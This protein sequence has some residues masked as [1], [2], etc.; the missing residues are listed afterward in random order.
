MNL[1]HTCSNTRLVKKGFINMT[2]HWLSRIPPF[3]QRPTALI[4]SL[5]LVTPSYATEYSVTDFEQLTQALT[6][7]NQNA[8]ADTI[9]ILNDINVSAPLPVIKNDLT[10]IGGDHV[11]N[12]EQQHRLLVI[13]NGAVNI[14]DLT[15]TQGKAQGGTGGGGGA[16]LGGALFIVDGQ[17][18]LDRVTFSNNIAQGGQGGNGRG[19]GGL[20]GDG[21]RQGHGGGGGGGLHGDGGGLGNGGGG[22]GGYFGFGGNGGQGLKGNGGGGGGGG[23]FGLG[24]NGGRYGG[25]GGGGYLENGQAGG[26]YGSGGQGASDGGGNGSG[27]GGGGGGGQVGNTGG[28]GIGDRG[29]FGGRSGGGGGGGGNSEKILADRQGGWGADGG[30]GG[31]GGGGGSGGRGLCA[32]NDS[33]NSFAGG[34]GGFGGFGGGGGGGG[35]GE[36]SLGRG[37]HGGDG[38]FGGGGGGGGDGR[39]STDYGCRGGDGGQGGFGGGGGGGGGYF[40]STTND[41]IGDGNSNGAAGGFGGGHGSAGGKAANGRGGGGAGFGGAVFIKSGLLT[42]NQVTFSQNSAI[43]G[44]AAGA[45]A[46]AGQGKGGGL[47]ICTR[48]EDISCDAEVTIC[49]N[50]VSFTNNQA[51][52]DNNLPDDNDNIY[53]VPQQLNCN[54]PPWV[55]TPIPDVTVQF[56]AADNSFSLFPYFEDA[57]DA[58]PAL[59][60]TLSDNTVPAVVTPTF[61]SLGT[62]N[63]DF[64]AVGMSNVTIRATDSGQLFVEDSFKVTVLAAELAYFRTEIINNRVHFSWETYSEHDNAGFEIW[65][66]QLTANKPIVLTQVTPQLVAAQANAVTG[67]EYAYVDNQPIRAAH[68][69]YYVLA[70]VDFDGQTTFHWDLLQRVN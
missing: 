51:T 21:G 4:I 6:V 7:A 57:E 15:L 48:S 45:D 47:F 62:L 29:G 33:E 2:T 34:L 66:A 65:R 69:Y 64:A 54:T 55:M 23:Y 3:R 1:D 27:Y 56:G 26:D 40:H 35:F 39:G 5:A 42:L 30:A 20:G 43:R 31:F 67:A 41:K 52:D 24:G 37:G 22:G 63:L 58:D 11:L 59:T 9:Q 12:G 10:L 18:R 70:D 19:G 50:S 44:A 61:T 38:G 49:N 46:S 14:T 25:G 68:T 16:G 60:Y 53:G 8:S 28:N 13:I 36:G 32:Q 17:I